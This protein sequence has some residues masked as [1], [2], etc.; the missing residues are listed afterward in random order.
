MNKDTEKRTSQ[1]LLDITEDSLHKKFIIQPEKALENFKTF[2]MQTSLLIERVQ[3]FLPAIVK[4][5]E[6]L[7]ALS[8]EAKNEL[9][10][11]FTENDDKVIEMSLSI[12]DDRLIISEDED[13]DDDDDDD[14]GDDDHDN[15]LITNIVKE[16]YAH[17]K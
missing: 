11:E 13:V 7:A 4:G 17:K 1:D 8:A 10:I 3:K 5:N 9:N 14:H 6:C 15:T 12:V 2:R 16:K